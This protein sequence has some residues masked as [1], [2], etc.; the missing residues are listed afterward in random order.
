[1][2]R[3]SH[4]SRGIGFVQRFAGRITS[5]GP[6]PW[7]RS[8]VCEQNLFF[9]TRSYQMA[10]TASKTPLQAIDFAKPHEVREFPKGKVELITVNGVTFGRVTFNPGWR[11]STHIKPIAGTDSC[12]AAHLGVQL[13]GVMH[14]KMD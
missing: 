11:W 5:L 12:Q 3:I 6:F 4:L 14:I 8:R 13:S 7:V 2:A 10:A 1:G 9:T